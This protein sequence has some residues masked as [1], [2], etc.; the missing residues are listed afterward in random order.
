LTQSVDSGLKIYRHELCY[1]AYFAYLG[2]KY[3][4]QSI[5]LLG[6]YCLVNLLFVNLVIPKTKVLD[7]N[8]NKINWLCNFC[9]T[10]KKLWTLA[11]ILLNYVPGAKCA[12]PQKAGH[13]T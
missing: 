12:L 3:A 8:H 13:I 2:A 5:I 9:F 6:K 11:F 10:Q 1:T 4:P 7:K